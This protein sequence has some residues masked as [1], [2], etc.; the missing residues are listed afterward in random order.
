MEN[1]ALIIGSLSISYSGVLLFLGAL[2]GSCLLFGLQRRTN[3]GVSDAAALLCPG[4]LLS[5]PLSRFLHWY[6]NSSQYASF[7]SAL[8]DYGSGGYVVLGVYAAFLLSALLLW[9]LGSIRKLPAL[10]DSLAPA[11]ALALAIVKLSCRFSQVCRS[12]FSF[13]SESLRRLPFMIA[14]T[15]SNGGTEWRIATFCLQAIAYLLVCAAALLMLQ[16]KK[17]AGDTFALTLSL[18]GAVQVVL[19]STRY[20]AAYFRSN[21]FVSITQV[22]CVSAL[23]IVGIV[24]SVRSVRSCGGV[25][26]R[27]ILCWLLYALCAGVGGYC[28]YYVQRHAGLFLPTYAVMGGCFLLCHGVNCVLSRTDTQ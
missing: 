7:A 25:K 23:V 3:T 12:K 13:E 17:R 15:L 24:F 14:S 5:V 21:G 27:H 10:L 19:D 11:G 8:T 28:E 4:L 6:S 22:F 1:T 20:D 26:L 2:S 9:A 18:T 16:K